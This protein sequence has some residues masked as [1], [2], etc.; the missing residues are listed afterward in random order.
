MILINAQINDRGW[1]WRVIKCTR[2]QNVHKSPYLLL[3]ARYVP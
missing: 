3:L 2:F 1:L